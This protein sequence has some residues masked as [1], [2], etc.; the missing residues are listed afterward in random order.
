MTYIK[1]NR[2][3]GHYRNSDFMHPKIALRTDFVFP[4]LSLLIWLDFTIEYSPGTGSVIH[5]IKNPNLFLIDTL[6]NHSKNSKRNTLKSNQLIG[7]LKK[8]NKDMKYITL[9]KSLLMPPSAMLIANVSLINEFYRYKNTPTLILDM[10]HDKIEACVETINDKTLGIGRQ[11]FFTIELPLHIPNYVAMNKLIKYKDKR[12]LSE[13]NDKRTLLFIEL[14]KWFDEDLGSTSYFDKILP[15]MYVNTTILFTSGENVVMVNLND[16][17]SLVKNKGYGD[18]KVKGYTVD[19]AKKVFLLLTISA[20]VSKG[21]PISDLGKY[22]NKISAIGDV[23]L[24][25]IDD[26]LDILTTSQPSEDLVK[27]EGE[28]VSDIVRDT[29]SLEELNSAQPNVKDKAISALNDML[30]K[31]ELTD[32]QYKKQLKH[33]AEQDK[34]LKELE[35]SP[36]E[37]KID[38]KLEYLPDNPTVEDKTLLKNKI[39]AIRTTYLDKSHDKNIKRA[40]YG[41]QS[42]GHVVTDVQEDVTED[43][44]GD[45]TDY[46]IKMSTADKVPVTLKLRIPKLDKDGNFKISGNEYVMR[47]M[48]RSNP[49]AKIKP[50]EVMLS[51]YY[52]K[53]AITRDKYSKNALNIQIGK[54]LEKN[55]D[56]ENLILGNNYVNQEGIPYLYSNISKTVKTF[57]L[58][59]NYFLFSYRTRYILVNK[60]DKLDVIEK[61]GLLIGKQGRSYLLLVKDEVFLKDTKGKKSLGSLL[62]LMGINMKN[63]PT[64]VTTMRVFAKT[65]PMIL[66]LLHKY[67]FSQLLHITKATYK[68]VVFSRG[69][70][71]EDD[72]Y[73][74]VFL[75]FIYIFKRDNRANELLFGGLASLRETNDISLKHFDNIHGLSNIGSIIGLDKSTMIEIKNIHNL[76]LDPITANTLKKLNE[77]TEFVPLLL[78]ANELLLQDYNPKPT[79]LNYMNIVGDERIAGMMYKELSKSIRNYESKKST[80]RAKISVNPYSVWATMNSDSTTVLVED[81]N[82]VGLLKQQADVS[83][84]GEFGVANKE[85]MMKENRAY[86]VSD[87]GVISGDVKDSS[88]VGITM[89]MSADPKLDG[90]TGLKLQDGKELTAGNIYSPSSLL[91]VDSDKDD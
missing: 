39:K 45:Y 86:H 33:L 34:I 41:L 78:R 22:E 71:L 52:G 57:T 48:R 63:L 10:L 55:P 26:A 60:N 54:Q 80:A 37:A 15:E 44:L 67:T 30:D 5:H 28:T 20:L 68:K 79:D 59:K 31:G 12:L 85:S 53:L 17:K 9:S 38:N 42:S 69:I 76:F 50:T 72:E 13:T 7:E 82:P 24:D 43:I 87:V 23:D 25:N 65:L 66:V 56:I 1:L 2:M 11:N 36:D 89:Y 81:L 49:I 29:P 35:Y 46:T 84:T 75:D 88:D 21:L 77:P 73:K 58:G 64:Q 70:S 18:S 47:S 6:K 27:E 16:L 90:T 32:A 3:L 51:S 40:F 19:K 4:K 74:V 8:S 61:D 62:P 83:Y 14:Y 91:F